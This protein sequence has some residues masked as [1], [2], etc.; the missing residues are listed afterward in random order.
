[1]EKEFEI[2]KKFS[3]YSIVKQFSTQKIPDQI[4]YEII[5]TANESYSA[6]N[7]Q[8]WHFILV[9]DAELKQLLYKT[10]L[11][12]QA[13]LDA[14]CTLV[15]IANPNAWRNSYKKLLKESVLSNTISEND[16]LRFSHEVYDFF[17]LGSFG[18]L[19][20]L[21]HIGIAIKRLWRP[22]AFPPSNK[23]EVDNFITSQTFFAASAFMTA[24]SAVGLSASPIQNFDKE[25]TKKLLSI[26]P[27]MHISMLIPFGYSLDKNLLPYHFPIPK[28][29]SLDLYPNKLEKFKMGLSR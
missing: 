14:P 11:N 15:L 3:K 24:A 29:L 4:V 28:K 5:E 20:F 25:R 13:I 1:M 19:G 12:Q 10:A 18:I 22:S 23:K 2:I 8:P 7:L 27:R 26:P 17:N 16:A 6:F 9:R 21:K